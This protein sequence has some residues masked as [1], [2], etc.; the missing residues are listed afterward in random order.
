MEC[1][2]CGHCNP[3]GARYCNSC[4]KRVD[5][6][7]SDGARKCAACGRRMNYDVYFNVCQHCGFTYR[8]S[9]SRPNGTKAPTRLGYILMYYASMAIPAAGLIIG[10]TYV[11][12]SR[13]ER[14]FKLDCAV[15]GLANL[16]ILGLI[17]YYLRVWA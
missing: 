4:G 13:E 3:E 1:G 9:I 15:L 16:A 10:G 5:R 12:T 8:I 17:A 11:P 2:H 14:R 7:D 6:G